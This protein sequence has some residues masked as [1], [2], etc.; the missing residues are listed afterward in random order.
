MPELVIQTLVRTFRCNPPFQEALKHEFWNKKNMKTLKNNE[1]TEYHGGGLY[2]Q[3][4]FK[5]N[6]Q[7]AT[8]CYSNCQTFAKT[9]ALWDESLQVPQVSATEMKPTRIPLANCR[10][11]L[12]TCWNH[13]MNIQLQKHKAN[14]YSEMN[15]ISYLHLI[16]M[17]SVSS[18]S[19]HHTRSYVTHHCYLLLLVAAVSNALLHQTHRQMSHIASNICHT[20]LGACL[21]R[22]I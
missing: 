6:N 14:G 11:F 10:Y 18:S 1:N 12:A 2:I 19:S 16:P 5:D 9:T 17:I 4:T 8:V 15:Q 3:K 22:S 21:P 20:K 13:S 7:M